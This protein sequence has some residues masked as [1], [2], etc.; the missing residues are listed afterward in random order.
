MTTTTALRK[1]AEKKVSEPLLAD[2]QHRDAVRDGAALV[3]G[4][5]YSL[6]RS[7]GKRAFD[8]LASAVGLLLLT[9]L[10][11]ASAL[12]VKLS[13]PGPV[14][15]RQV[16]LGRH[17]VPFQ[18]LKLRTMR[19]SPNGRPCYLT[20][21]DDPRITRVGRWFRS[22]KIDELPQLINVLRGEMSL[23]G[24]R[25][26][27][28][29]LLA[30]YAPEPE[31]IA[32]APGM[33]GLSTLCYRHQE[34][35]LDGE[36]ALDREPW[37]RE[38]TQLEKQYARSLSFALDLKLIFLTLA[39]LYLP[40]PERLRLK[41]ILAQRSFPYPAFLPVLLDIVLVFFALV[42]SYWLRFEGELSDFH[43]LQLYLLLLLLPFLRVALSGA[44][45]LYERL[46]RYTTTTDILYLFFVQSLPT[47]ALLAVRLSSPEAGTLLSFFSLP[48]SIVALEYLATSFLTASARLGRHLLYEAS[49]S[50]APPS[51]DDVKRV[52]LA[53]AG[54]LGMAVAGELGT[55]RHVDLVG[56]VDDDPRKKARR[57]QGL[58][59]LGGVSD[60]GRIVECYRPTHVLVCSTEGNGDFRQR[61]EAVLQG[62]APAPMVKG[63]LNL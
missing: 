55:L 25:A 51:S 5:G 35:L 52:V 33:T 28:P 29:E 10:L 38:K 11:A 16:R 3:R 40:G 12:L 24:P 41:D 61:V 50:Y 32:L 17:G 21:G 60:L 42:G 54:S 1:A 63:V 26:R 34:E 6:Y 47:L 19:V 48:L 37:Y 36:A 22:L 39:I 49:R 31:L 43:L 9:P 57:F 4:R 62:S 18:L 8:L 14:F 13:S 30:V 44:L 46:W 53:G 27:V 59:V 23:V 56:F 7:G 15:F 2:Q 58:P 20:R 45:G